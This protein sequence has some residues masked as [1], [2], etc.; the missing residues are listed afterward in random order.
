MS[1]NICVHNMMLKEFGLDFFDG[2][3][4]P[5]SAGIELTAK[6]NLRCIHCYAQ[7]ERNHTDMTTEQ[8]KQVIDI[9]VD[10]GCLSIFYTGG[11]V[12]CRKDFAELYIYARKK[13]LL[14]SV[15]SNI[16]MLTEEHIQL[17]TEYPIT[18]LSTTMYGYEEDT[19][20][21]VTGVKGSYKNFMRALDLVQKSGIPYE[22]KFIG[23]EQNIDDVYKCRAFAKELGVNMI[24]CF[25][26]RATSDGCGEPIN[27][28]I[29]PE[30]AFEFDVKDEGRHAFW[31]ALAKQEYTAKKNH[32]EAHDFA[33]KKAGYLYPCW[34]SYQAVF[35]TSEGMMQG[36]ITASYK[37]YDLFKGNFDEGWEYLKTEFY[38]K[39]AS[40]DF[41]CLSCEKFTYCE[42]CTANPALEFKD[43]EHISPFHCRVAELRK[44]MVDAEIAR[45]ELLDGDVEE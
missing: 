30:R 37:Q 25:D 12:L 31:M 29:S 17:F 21:A 10:H 14:V 1:E 44:E 41:E 42:Q 16:T 20:E 13:G 11:E 5:F 43:E 8:V 15:L 45:L 39:K 40:P 35:I 19:Y 27:Y 4:A 32:V 36:C 28:R 6:C 18:Q 23:M 33:R 7:N 22:L 9:L 3:S 38:D 34:I 26:I 2:V 24:T